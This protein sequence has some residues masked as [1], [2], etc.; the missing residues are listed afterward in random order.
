LL[1]Q[2]TQQALSELIQIAE[3]VAGIKQFTGRTQPDV[4][5]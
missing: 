4:I 1:A 3:S 2:E 5:T